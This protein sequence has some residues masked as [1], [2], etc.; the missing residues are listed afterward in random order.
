MAASASDQCLGLWKGRKGLTTKFISVQVWTWSTFHTAVAPA[1]RS[2]L[3]KWWHL[4]LGKLSET[5]KRHPYLLQLLHG[6]L[7][8]AQMSSSLP[9]DCLQEV[10]NLLWKSLHHTS[11]AC[12]FWFNWANHSITDLSAPLE[13]HISCQEHLVPLQDRKQLIG[14]TGVRT[15]KH[16]EWVSS[17]D[18]CPAKPVCWERLAN[19]RTL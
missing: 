5:S 13:L 10:G 18:T 9:G 3:E 7:C 17:Q 19:K 6:S 1:F 16:R 8:L 15:P 12:Y 2:A 11:T 4:L 14:A